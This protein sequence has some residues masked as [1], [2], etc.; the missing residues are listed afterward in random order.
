MRSLEY[1]PQVG[2]RAVLLNTTHGV[3]VVGCWFH[4]HEWQWLPHRHR[5]WMHGIVRIKALKAAK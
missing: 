4:E 3:P 1:E 5:P 2:D